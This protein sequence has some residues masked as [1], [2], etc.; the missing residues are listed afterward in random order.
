MFGHYALC[1]STQ[2]VLNNLLV[3]HLQMERIHSQYAVMKA[4]LSLFSDNMMAPTKYSNEIY[5]NMAAQKLH[6]IKII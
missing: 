6:K 2:L 3:H 1:V 5:N 4:C